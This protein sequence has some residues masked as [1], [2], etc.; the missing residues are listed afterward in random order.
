MH[1]PGQI[2]RGDKMGWSPTGLTWWLGQTAV[3]PTSWLPTRQRSDRQGTQCPRL[4][5]VQFPPDAPDHRETVVCRSANAAYCRTHTNLRLGH[6]NRLSDRPS[7]GATCER[8]TRW[9]E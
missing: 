9:S 8:P 2:A 5:A 3:P 7:V 6:E 4:S 1:R